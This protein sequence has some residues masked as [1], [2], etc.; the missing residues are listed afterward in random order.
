MAE[1]DLQEVLGVVRR[2]ARSRA[3]H[4]HSEDVDAGDLEQIA[5]LR[6]LPKLPQ[7]NP[8]YV[9]RIAANAIVDYW[10]EI[11]GRTGNKTLGRVRV[12]P[13][14]DDHFASLYEGS[15]SYESGQESDDYVRWIWS[16]L[17]PTERKIVKMKMDGMS[18]R[19]IDI[20]MERYEGFVDYTLRLMRLRL[21]TEIKDE[22]RARRKAT[23][24]WNYR[25]HVRGRDKDGG[26][27]DRRRAAEILEASR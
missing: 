2:V 20:E 22:P 13:G 16:R 8:R 1:L 23:D 9:G 19:E 11:Y 10:R 14:A 25:R 18:H 4:F 12:H 17:V 5:M 7:R 15:V 27:V 26:E 24:N 21:E 6:V 3:K